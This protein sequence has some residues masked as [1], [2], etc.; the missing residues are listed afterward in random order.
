MDTHVLV[1]NLLL[2]YQ[3]GEGHQQQWASLF[4]HSM[5]VQHR[6]QS[7]SQAGQKGPFLAKVGLISNWHQVGNNY[8]ACQQLLGT[9]LQAL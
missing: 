7:L 5:Q 1:Q 8:A 4:T 2:G 6:L 3:A 9:S